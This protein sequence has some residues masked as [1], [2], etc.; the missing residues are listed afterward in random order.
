MYWCILVSIYSNCGQSS[1]EHQLYSYIINFE[2]GKSW[3]KSINFHYVHEFIGF[4]RFAIKVL[5]LIHD[6]YDYNDEEDGDI[7]HITDAIDVIDIA[8]Y[9]VLVKV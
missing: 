5:I 7:E 3:N 8:C 4:P 1:N 9:L 2:I 6:Y